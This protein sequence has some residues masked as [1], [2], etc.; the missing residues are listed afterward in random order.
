MQKL[1]RTFEG[2]LTC[3]Q[4]TPDVG[5]VQN[6]RPDFTEPLAKKRG[7]LANMF[8]AQSASAEKPKIAKQ[9]SPSGSAASSSKSPP[10]AP[11]DESSPSKSLGIKEGKVKAKTGETQRTETTTKMPAKAKRKVRDGEAAEE[12]ETITLDDSDEDSNASVKKGKSPAKKI[13]RSADSSGNTKLDSFF[14]TVD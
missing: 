6:D 14:P 5:K 7:T 3:Y 9:G 11:N 1:V 10:P 4:V 12:I 13:K 2:E 8:A